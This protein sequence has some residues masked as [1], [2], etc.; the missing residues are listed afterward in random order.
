MKKLI[1]G[2]TAA[3]LCALAPLSALAG[4]FEDGVAAYEAKNYIGAWLYFNEL[5]NNGHSGAQIF[6][7]AMYE[8][9][10]AAVSKSDTK[11]ANWYRKAAQQGNALGQ[12]NLGVMHANGKGVPQSYSEAMKW[13]K[14]SAAQGSGNAANSIGFLHEK[15]FGVAS[16]DIEAA[17]WYLKAAQQGSAIGQFNIGIMY[18]AG[19]GVPKNL[20]ESIH[21]YKKSAAQ[22]YQQAKDVLVKIDAQDGQKN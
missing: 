17:N 11:A 7:G 2:L 8:F 12:Y 13:Y 18:R 1:F 16:S 14:K 20:D 4:P 21:W 3:S 6:L 10:N 5:A 22:N 9:E 19:R 15:G